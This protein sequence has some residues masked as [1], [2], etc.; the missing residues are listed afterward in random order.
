MTCWHGSRSECNARWIVCDSSLIEK[1]GDLVEGYREISVGNINVK[2]IN[3][4]ERIR[5]LYVNSHGAGFIL[6]L[7]AGVFDRECFSDIKAQLIDRLTVALYNDPNWQL[8][9]HILNRQML[10]TP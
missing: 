7:D 3:G 10:P 6:E 9:Y 1:A 2:M 4:N 8:I 5:Y